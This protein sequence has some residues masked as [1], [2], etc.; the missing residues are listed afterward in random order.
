MSDTENQL[1]LRAE[2]EVNRKVLIALHRVDNPET[3]MH[4]SSQVTNTEST[5]KNQIREL[6]L[7]IDPMNIEFTDISFVQTT[8]EDDGA[9][10]LFKRK[11]EYID[12]EAIAQ[13]KPS[14]QEKITFWLTRGNLQIANNNFHNAIDCYKQVLLINS[15]QFVC[16]FNIGC[17][18]ERLE[19]YEAARKWLQLCYDLDFCRSDCLYG[20]ALCA[21]K[22]G[23][24]QQCFTY[25]E[26]LRRMSDKENPNV[27]YLVALS[28]REIGKNKEAAD[29]YMKVFQEIQKNIG[30][31]FA[32]KMFAS[33]L[34]RAQDIP[35]SIDTNEAKNFFESSKE[36]LL[37]KNSTFVFEGMYTPEN[38]WKPDLLEVVADRL[39]E[40]KFW[41]RFTPEYLRTFLGYMHVEKFKPDTVIF[42]PTDVVYIIASGSIS[43]RD[44]SPGPLSPKIIASLEEGDI[45]GFSPIDNDV[46]K[47]IENW[48]ICRSEI[49][50]LVIRT[51]DFARIWEAQKSVKKMIHTDILEQ[52]VLL[53]GITHQTLYT[54]SY[55]LAKKEVFRC[56][57][58]LYN[59]HSYMTV[60]DFNSKVKKKIL[61]YKF[62]ELMDKD[63]PTNQGLSTQA[64]D[65]KA[66]RPRGQSKIRKYSQHQMDKTK[67]KASDSNR[68]TG[69]PRLEENIVRGIFIILDGEC[70]VE[71]AEKRI[72]TTLTRG[73]YFG[74]NLLLGTVSHNNFGLI[75]CKTPQVEVLYISKTLF[76]RIPKY[77]VE[78][79]TAI[80]T[81]VRRNKKRPA[82]H[83]KQSHGLL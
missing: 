27:N 21:Y 32:K 38:E 10:H 29:N 24:S 54:L 41:K 9:I 73:D 2:Q 78:K 26:E 58:V 28:C 13:V 56:G 20:L 25:L 62:Y 77:D 79:M 74:E 36:Y 60:Q 57:E 31:D 65:E 22:S 59:D 51:S 72:V 45:I 30:A 11:D 71:N 70:T 43:F 50:V 3:P 34:L 76:N 82:A 12:P 37:T 55:E 7:S 52:T 8:A 19:N 16:I 80:C 81:E 64:R 66:F 83:F 49:E 35:F 67:A 61:N 68:A 39:S 18:F 4:F 6:N 23:N 46:Y 40:M 47:N 42:P 53:R 69:P 1:K 5:T 63:D 33:L 75:R 17:M 48:M 15:Q 44:H 14:G